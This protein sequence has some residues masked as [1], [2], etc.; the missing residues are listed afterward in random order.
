[1]GSSWIPKPTHAHLQGLE[2]MFLFVAKDAWTVRMTYTVIS[3]LL[4]FT[5]TYSL[6]RV[7]T[8]HNVWRPVQVE[9][10][11]ITL[12]SYVKHRL[13]MSLIVSNVTKMV[14]ANNV[15]LTTC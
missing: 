4:A 15:L 9:P 11:P 13:V 2:A 12:L 7:V 6:T 3:V 1:M 14:N 5:D 10:S 8:E